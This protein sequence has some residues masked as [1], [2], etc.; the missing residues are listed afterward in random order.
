[1]YK[2]LPSKKFQ[3]IIL[4]LLI[5]LG[6]IYFL[7]YISKTEK[8]VV[9]TPLIKEIDPKLSALMDQDADGDKLKD[10]E[11]SLWKTD[12]QKIDTDGDGT[13]DGEE[14]ALSRD[15]LKPNTAKN[16]EVPTDKISPEVADNREKITEDFSQLTTTEKMSRE[17]F[18]QY[19]ASVRDGS[20]LTDTEIQNI[21]NNTLSY[22]PS[23]T[24]KT[25]TSKDLS[26]SLTND[27]ETYRVYSNAIAKI[28]LQN[29]VTETETVDEIIADTAKLNT[30]Q[31]QAEQMGEIFKRFDP[32]IA[33][34][35]RSVDELLKVTVPQSFLSEHLGLLNAWQE[36]YESLDLMQQSTNDLIILVILNNNYPLSIQNLSKA[37]LE[38]TK[39][40]YTKKIIY[41]GDKNFGN[42]L[43]NVKIP[44]K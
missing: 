7:N 13:N 34:N 3:L 21:V 17:L 36:I 19:I 43:F 6:L 26:T 39:E 9:K 1:M 10:W 14:V 23:I 41:T 25:Y 31:K 2:Y 11:E 38:M 42:Y 8:V 29:L 24:F 4:S 30:P 12:S 16:N 18:L 32:L 20:P 15:P 5:V 35:K 37:T 40:I 33:K 28:I 27:N 44:G 22:V